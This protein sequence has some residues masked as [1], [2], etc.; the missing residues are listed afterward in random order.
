MAAADED[1]A[2]DG[3]PKIL[4]KKEKEKLKKEREKVSIINV[5]WALFANMCITR[6]RKRHRLQRR[7]LANLKQRRQQ[8]LNPRHLPPRQRRQAKRRMKA[9]RAPLVVLHPRRKRKR[10]Q[11]RTRS[12][13]L[14][15]PPGR[16]RELLVLVR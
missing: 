9:T 14:R 1:D 15:L 12:Q 10:R 4:S 11:R 16:R 7:R 3:G 8:L 5:P 13:H 6:L 2:E